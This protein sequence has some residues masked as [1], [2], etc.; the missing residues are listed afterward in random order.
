MNAEVV[1]AINDALDRLWETSDY[2]QRI[3]KITQEL[4]PQQ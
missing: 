1:D 3:K 2:S 4:Q